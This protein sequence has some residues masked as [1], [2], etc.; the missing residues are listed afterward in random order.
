[1]SFQGR[2]WLIFWAILPVP[3]VAC[4]NVL[5]PISSSSPPLE[6]LTV[7]TTASAPSARIG[8]TPWTEAPT[9]GTAWWLRSYWCHP[10]SRYVS[11]LKPSF[12]VKLLFFYDWITLFVAW[13]K[14]YFCKFDFAFVSLP[15]CQ[16]KKQS[17]ISL[18]VQW[19]RLHT[20]TAGGTGSI[21]GSG[22]RITHATVCGQKKERKKKISCTINRNIPLFCR[23]VSQIPQRGV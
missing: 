2:F 21:P 12:V 8:L 16:L 4:I 5:L 18:A 17:V 3:K 22:T 14:L 6:W 7:T 1:M 11:F 13:Q 10:K 9:P 23:S 19:L 15:I 20:S